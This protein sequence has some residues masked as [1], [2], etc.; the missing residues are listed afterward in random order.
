MKRGCCYK[1]LE[2]HLAHECDNV[3]A[4]I[5]NKY[6]HIVAKRDGLSDDIMEIETSQI[7]DNERNKDDALSLEQAAFIDHSVLK[8]FVMCGLSFRI[9]EIPYFINIL[10]NLKKITIH[11]FVNGFQLIY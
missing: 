11:H 7:T 6:M 8:A 10:K 1:K 4:E 2:V 9:I 3:S 5:K